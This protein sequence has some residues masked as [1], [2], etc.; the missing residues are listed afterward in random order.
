MPSSNCSCLAGLE[1]LKIEEEL[2][3]NAK[4][5]DWEEI[6]PM[7]PGCRRSSRGAAGDERR[8]GDDRRTEIETATGEVEISRI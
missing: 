7:M 2:A 4:I 8:F 6:L 5:R 1:I 3:L